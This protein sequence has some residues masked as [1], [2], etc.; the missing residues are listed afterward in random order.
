MI[1]GVANVFSLAM[2]F[3]LDILEFQRLFYLLNY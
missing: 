1:K 2:P 3:I